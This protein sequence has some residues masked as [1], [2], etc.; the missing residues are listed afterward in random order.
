MIGSIMLP[1]M[2]GNLAL[3]DTTCIAAFTAPQDSWPI[4]T[5]SGTFSTATAYSTEPI[6]TVSSVLPALRMMNSSP[7]PRPNR[8]SGGTRESEQVT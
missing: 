7:K 6:A 4:T 2:P 8:S 5:T 1:I 3:S